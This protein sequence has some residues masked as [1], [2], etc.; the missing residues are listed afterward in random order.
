MSHWIALPIVLPAML[1]AFIVLVARFH[2]TIQ[3]VF[4]LAGTTALVALAAGLAWNAS[5]GTITLYQMG[6]W[7]APF[8]I[9][10]VGDR[11]STMMVLLT[12]VLA[13]CVLLYAI[14][15]GWDKRGQHFHAL[16]QF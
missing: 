11:L 2:L 13:M 3:R 10:L 15:S 8:G 16:Y 12:A 9:V 6:D 1:A 4:N 14:G 7:A 5:D